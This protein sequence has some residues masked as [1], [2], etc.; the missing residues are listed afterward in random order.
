MS[1]D[2]ACSLLH[3]GVIIGRAFQTDTYKY[4]YIKTIPEINACCFDVFL[5]H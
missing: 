3:L 2:T 1:V 4:S 5:F